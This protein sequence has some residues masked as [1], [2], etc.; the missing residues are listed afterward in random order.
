MYLRGTAS[1]SLR[2]LLLTSLIASP[3]TLALAQAGR[4]GISGTVND[5]SGAHVA[6]A[7]V[8][9]QDIAKGTKLSTTT[10]TAGVYSFVSV[11]PGQYTVTIS[12]EGFNTSVQNNI[13]VTVDQTNTVN[14]TLEVGSLNQTVTVDESASLIEG[15]SSTVGQLISSQTI[16]RVPLVTRDVYQLVQLSAGVNPTNGTPNASDTPGIFNARSLVDVS[17][18]TVNGALQGSVYYNV[19]GAPIGI[20]ENSI[21]TIIPA[22]QV[23]EDGVEEFRVETQNTPASYASGGGGVVSIVTKSGSNKLHG[24][25]FGYF[26][27]NALAAADYFYKQA[28]PGLGTPDFHRYQEGASIAGP[29]KKDKLFFFGDYEATQQASLETGFFTVPTAAERTGDFS[30]DALTIYNPLVPDNPDGTRQPFAGNIIPTGN[31]D[32]VAQTFAALLPLPNRA[33]DGGPFHIN[34]YAGSGLD[35]FHSQKFDIRLDYAQSEKNRLFGRFSYG[36][37][38]FGNSDLYGANNPYD[39][40]FYTNTTNTR[41]ILIG[42]DLT[43]TPTTILQLRYSFTRHFENQTGDPRN[44]NANIT[45]FGFPQS[46]ADQ[47]LYKTAP[48]IYFSTTAAVGGTG[49]YDTFV[50][51]SE[52]SDASATLTK[53]V[54]KHELSTG[55]EYQKKF[56]NVGQPPYP[57]GQYTFDNTATSSTT[58]AG[59]G[60]DFAS[61]LIGMG[62]TPGNES[63]NFTKDVFAAEANPYYAAFLADNFR[64]SPKFTLNLGL[65]WEIFGGRTERFNR[66]EYWDPSLAFSVGGAHLTGGERF[67]TPA[68]RS[69]FTTN[70][71]DFAPRV[72]FAYNPQPNFV[73]RGGA[74]IYYGPSQNMVAS[75]AFNTDG[76]GSVSTWNATQYNANG[77]TVLLNPLSNP[78]PNGVVQPTGN[79][80]GPATNLGAG[81][82]SVY[83]SPRTL[84]TYNFNL[85]IQYQFPQDTVFSLAYV[86]S[87]GLFLPL[88]GV[89]L[90]TFSLQTIAQ[91]QGQLCVTGSE[92]NCVTAPNPYAGL[93]PAT[94]PYAGVATIPL[95]LSLEPYGQFNNGGYGSGVIINGLP[96]ADS[97]YSSLQAKVEKRM[98]HHLSSIAS[99]TWAKLMTDDSQPPFGFVGYHSGAPQDWRNLNLEHSVSAQDVRF[100]FNWQISWDLPIGKGRLLNLNGLSNTLLGGWTIN[101]ITYLSDGTP[102]ASPSGT[103]NPYFNQRVNLSCDPR[104][105]ARRN[106]AQWFNYTCFSQP[107]NQFV[108]G[109]APAF[110]ADLRTDGAHQ[111]DVSLYKVFPF[112]SE[113]N[114]RL[115]VAG[116]NITNTVQYGYPNVFW[117]PA[118]TTDPT[119]LT[120]FGQVTN[121]ANQPRQFQFG[122]RFTF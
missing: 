116:F 62:S 102:I 28:N 32:P 68:N 58:F 10:T 95:W 61:F 85:G 30:A 12:H 15:S 119:V 75:P 4:G 65:R 23:P 117:N 105:V 8:V 34:N 40:Y 72:S 109:T 110:L 2:A 53:V 103:G 71:K 1:S 31:L 49:N 56:L 46:L 86:G 82:S 78:F 101:T 17:A 120:G 66:Q 114:L 87:R 6:G 98:S 36:R 25:L 59:D 69:P 41:N 33:G 9:A 44:S 81:L 113:R 16:D 35:P 29:I 19:D 42:D 24:D 38:N 60:S 108:P 97:E 37:I 73:L 20:A 92:A 80:L 84:T 55:F 107:T 106:A 99:F 77:N 112:T 79:T 94:N 26:R 121:A 88:G 21:A 64:V 52:N 89:D 93:Y 104:S 67:V 76:F 50:F 54:G 13:T 3:A 51:A 57:A 22:F 43:I 14:I 7:T 11:A 115:E 83:H 63:V 118:V 91:Y 111:A 27:P 122:A 100:Q 74:G 96:G 45:D 5:A 70:L 18:Y 39:P 90:N 47:V 48:V